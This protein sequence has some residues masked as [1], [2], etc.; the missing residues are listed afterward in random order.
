MAWFF[1]V[2]LALCSAG[3][4]GYALLLTRRLFRAEVADGVGRR[5][6][7]GV[8]RSRGSGSTPTELSTT[9]GET[10]A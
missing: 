4:L 5:A 6:T 3:I 1:T 10:R 7:G 8:T 2:L 9:T